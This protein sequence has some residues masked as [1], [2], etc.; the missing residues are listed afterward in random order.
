MYRA[1]LEQDMALFVE[2]AERFAT[3]LVDH[4]IDS[5][6]GDALEGYNPTHDVCR[7]LID[8]AVSIAEH[9]HRRSIKNYAFPLI[10]TASS[11]EVPAEAW[12]TTLSPVQLA[13]KLAESRRYAEA[14]GGE[15]PA[16]LDKLLKAS[17]QAAF[18][19]E[20][21]YPMDTAA[22][23]ARFQSEKPFYEVHG[24]KRVAAGQYTDVI[25][26]RQHMAPIAAALAVP[27]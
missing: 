15:L 3:L 7:L 6:A 16:E 10:A 14:A 13:Q 20:V 26:F 24:E 2:L 18:A 22:A 25:R 1:I 23:L 5:M 19:Q 4:A 12:R 27:S 9:R 21:L 17:G 8:K 11:A